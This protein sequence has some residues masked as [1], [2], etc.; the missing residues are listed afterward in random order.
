MRSRFLLLACSQKKRLD[1]APLPAIERYDGPAYKVLRR[2]VRVHPHG[3]PEVYILSA[4]HGLIRGD[5]PIQAYDRKMTPQRACELRDQVAAELRTLELGR[6][7]EHVFVYAGNVY[8]QALPLTSL[9]SDSLT[10]ATGGPGVRLSQLK[11]WLSPHS[12]LSSQSDSEC[13]NRPAAHTF[14]LRGREYAVMPDEVSS[15][16]RRGVQNAVVEAL[17]IAAWYVQVDGHRVAPKWLVSQLTGLPLGAFHSDESRRVLN[18]LGFSV[19]LA[20][21]GLEGARD[22]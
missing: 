5:A 10:I 12:V 17:R 2:Y 18:H 14:K 11:A 6:C 7:Y 4:Q 15:I 22:D 20:H 3:D 19:L 9:P 1:A 16:A 21:P 13:R 8:R